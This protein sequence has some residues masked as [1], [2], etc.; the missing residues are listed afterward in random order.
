VTSSLQGVLFDMDGL[1]VDTEPLWFEAE[2]TVMARLGG[3]WGPAD[4]HQ[5]L[6]G[7]LERTVSYML[8][9]AAADGAAHRDGA[10][11]GTQLPARGVLGEWL[12]TA[13]DGLVRSR[14]V[15][16]LPGARELLGATAAAGLPHAL[17]TSSQRQLMR[18]VLAVTGLEFPVTV[19]GQDVTRTKPDP[20]PYLRAAALLG[21]DPARCVALEDSP[22]GVTA[23]QAA[24]CAVVM[25]P[26]LPASQ[27]PAQPA[28]AQ[29]AGAQPAGAQPARARPGPVVAGSLREISLERLQAVAAAHLAAVA[30]AA[31]CDDESECRPG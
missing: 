7:S 29:P 15:P 22:S 28:A 27:R 20:E 16:V 19:C 25:V 21:A 1:L 14:G 10:T 30:P 23:A 31:I 11:L 2:R 8:G 5:L 13:M 26:S 6:G 17:V 18:T 24:G 12:M 3:Q 4:Q 9:K